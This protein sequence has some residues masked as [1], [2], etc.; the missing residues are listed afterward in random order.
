VDPEFAAWAGARQ[1]PAVGTAYL[2]HLDHRR[3]EAAAVEALAGVAAR[4]DPAGEDRPDDVLRRCL[5]ATLRGRRARDAEEHDVRGATSAAADE[6]AATDDD[7]DEVERRERL[8]QAL[9]ALSAE[10]RSA[11]VLLVHEGRSSQ[12][13]PDLLGRSAARTRGA[14]DRARAALVPLLAPDRDPERLRLALDDL[15]D[16]AAAAPGGDLV[17]PAW[18]RSVDGAR[19]GRRR[20]VGGVAAVLAAAAVVVALRGGLG[21]PPEPGERAWR[22]VTTV[23]D[24]VD[25]VRGPTP[26]EEARLPAYPNGEARLGLPPRLGFDAD[27]VLPRLTPATGA[28]ATVRAVLLRRTGPAAFR[29]VLY[30]PG[31]T[32]PYVESDTVL[33]E[34]SDSFGRSRLALGPRTVADDRRRVVFAQSGAVVVLDGWTGEARRI[35]VPDPFLTSAGF[36]SGSGWVVARSNRERWRVDPRD[37]TVRRLGVDGY[38]GAAILRA[39][40]GGSQ[41]VVFTASGTPV[42]TRS[43]PELVEGTVGP[44]VTDRDGWLASGVRIDRSRAARAGGT[45]GVLA[46]EVATLSPV[47][48]MAEPGPPDVTTSCCAAMGWGSQQLLLYRSERPGVAR[49][50]GWDVRSGSL[51]RVSELP[52]DSGRVGAPVAQVA[53]AP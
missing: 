19:A 15:A 37:G 32:D 24:G 16:R 28:D 35:A 44:S 33:R 29:P 2:L 12:E 26:E 10:E 22:P 4:W 43:G 51:Q 14:A 9:A 53:L 21:P 46:A 36:T 45:S 23:V 1:R 48:L 47:A 27:A 39:S 7:P 20:L 25:V 40:P 34:P 38:A 11:L 41:V 49:L 13:A 3:A 8:R 30:R 31:A 18:R 42:G 17:D 6:P 5:H 50:L 52:A